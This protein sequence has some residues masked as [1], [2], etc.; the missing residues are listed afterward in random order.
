MQSKRISIAI[1]ASVV[2]DTPHLREKTAKIGLIGRAAAIFRV[3]RI[4]IYPDRPRVNQTYD[5]NEIAALLSYM[6]T[7][8]YLRKRL[9]HLEPN[10]QYAGILPPLRTAHHPL[11]RQVKKLKIGECREAV[12]LS[13]TKLGM[14]IDMGVEQTALIM[15]RQLP[16]N[17]RVTVK[18]VKKDPR[19]EVEIVDRESIP[20]Y[21]GYSIVTEKHAFG[22]IVQTKDFGVTIATSKYGCPVNS[23][24]D[25]VAEKWRT[26]SSILLAFGAPASGLNEIVKQEGLKLDDLVDFVVNMVPEQGTETIRTE[27]ALIAS[28][29]VLNTLTSKA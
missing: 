3:D 18:V 2:S 7:P 22:E 9:F 1:P 29:A 19:I 12:T 6:E 11:N 17:K 26:A 25:K 23:V 16:A 10:L 8:Q 13:H 4:I 14:L 24:V 21:W 27:E 20:G 15:N 5:A 28:L